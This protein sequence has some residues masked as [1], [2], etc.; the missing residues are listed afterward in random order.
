M[1]A[2]EGSMVFID[3]IDISFDVSID[4]VDPKTDGDVS[5][6]DPDDACPMQPI[7]STPKAKE[8]GWRCPAII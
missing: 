2:E 6:H 5:C 4:D 3:E 1:S 7:T 8:M